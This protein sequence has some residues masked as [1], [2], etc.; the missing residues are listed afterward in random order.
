MGVSMCLSVCVWCCV[1]VSVSLYE[2]VCL[3]VNPCPPSDAVPLLPFTTF[4]SA[5]PSTSVPSSS[6]IAIATVPT[7]FPTTVAITI[8]MCSHVTCM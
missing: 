8:G 7:P 2:L 5:V 6:S 4:F 1:G 3:H